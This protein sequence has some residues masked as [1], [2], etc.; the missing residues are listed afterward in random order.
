[1]GTLR[2]IFALAV[3]FSHSQVNLLCGGQN[4]VQLFYMISGF[5]ISFVLVERKAY[6]S[7]WSFYLNRYLR[8]YPIYFVVASLTLVTFLA[9]SLV[10]SEPEFFS[11][12]RNAPV[13]AGVLL[14]IA[15][16]TL[17]FQDWVMFAGVH[18]NKLSFVTDFRNS[19]VVLY[20]G[21]LLPQAWTLGV[22]LTFY[23][24]APFILVRK[25]LLFLLLTLSILLRIYLYWI[26]LGTKDPWTYRFFPAELAFFILGALA[27]QLLLPS[28]LKM[29]TE[30]RLNDY[31]NF[32][33]CFVI[34]V[35]LFYT[36]IPIADSIKSIALFSI[37]W[38]ALP[39]TFIFQSKRKWD[40]WIGNLSYPLYTCHILVIFSTN[41]VWNRMLASGS[42]AASPMVTAQQ[43]GFAQAV[44]SIWCALCL[45]RWVGDRFD[46]IRNRY[47]R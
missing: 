47:R 10:T 30:P 1:M 19:D 41:A 18:S 22:E 44:L 29:F 39:F 24:I 3:V 26:G 34:A 36:Y 42:P 28:Y 2:T 37:F 13:S 33:T 6:K 21:L 4:A 23:L 27:H 8:I 9:A 45:N 35:T 43:M 7:I 31:S 40:S 16:V 12:F 17:F 11:V 32:G 5:L 20:P 14:I 38:L 46:L 15:N 25:R